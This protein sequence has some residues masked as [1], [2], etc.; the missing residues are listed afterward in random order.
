MNRSPIFKRYRY[1]KKSNLINF[2]LDID[3]KSM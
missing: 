1:L 3:Y 2:Q